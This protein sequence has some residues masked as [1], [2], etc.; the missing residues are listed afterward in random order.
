MHF[1]SFCCFKFLY[2]I[3]WSAAFFWRPRKGGRRRA[4]WSF[5]PFP[6]GRCS[7]F[8]FS[9]SS[10]E[11][12]THTLTH[13]QLRVFYP[14][15]PSFLIFF[16]TGQERRKRLTLRPFGANER[17]RRLG[18]RFF[19]EEKEKTRRL[20]N[21]CSRNNLC[22]ECPIHHSSLTTQQLNPSLLSSQIH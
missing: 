15:P 1:F 10:K 3:P 11:A 18:T 6:P 9:L 4:R 2:S 21:R 17:E 19:L 16:T 7:S 13:T 5:L 12:H 14:P 8:S 20:W 22:C